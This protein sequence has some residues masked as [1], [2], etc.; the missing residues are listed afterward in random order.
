MVP[1]AGSDPDAETPIASCTLQGGTMSVFEDRVELDRSKRS[2]FEDKVIPLAEVYDVAYTPGILTGHIQI[3]QVGLEP[4][5]G[6]FLSHPVDE[7]TMYIP[8]AKRSAATTVRDEILSRASAT[9]PAG[10][11]DAVA[12]TDDEG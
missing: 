10:A 4:A 5:T 12:E 3:K 1:D 8:R 2:M 6:G 7:N 9:P 11:D